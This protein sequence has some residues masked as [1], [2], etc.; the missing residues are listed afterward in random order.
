MHRSAPPSSGPF[1][2]LCTVDGGNCNCRFPFPLLPHETD[3]ASR[4]RLRSS[5][6]EVTDWAR[7]LAASFDLFLIIYRHSL[8]PEGFLFTSV[9]ATPMPD[10]G[11]HQKHS[12]RSPRLKADTIQHFYDGSFINF[13]LVALNVANCRSSLLHF[14]LP[15]GKN[16][17][18]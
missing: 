16:C 7:I 12:M 18:L 10:G 8:R 2:P 13:L 3:P 4:C 15:T 14:A 5:L 11:P 9:R 6:R 1:S 17:T